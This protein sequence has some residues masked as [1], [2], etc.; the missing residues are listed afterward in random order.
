ML[1]IL[2]LW[3]STLIITIILVII[4]SKSSDIY[5]ISSTVDDHRRSILKRQLIQEATKKRSFKVIGCLSIIAF[6]SMIIMYAIAAWFVVT[7]QLFVALKFIAIGTLLESGMTVFFPMAQ[8]SYWKQETISNVEIM[9]ANT[10]SKLMMRRL[11]S[12]ILRSIFFAIPILFQNDFT[13]MLN[14]I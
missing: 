9:A 12:I 14:M 11:F 10:F 3:I 7:Q 6:F 4:N 1:G 2:L 13:N 5:H 8:Y